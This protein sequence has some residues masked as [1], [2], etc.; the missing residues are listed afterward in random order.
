[1]N[2]LFI[3]FHLKGHN[4]LKSHAVV[5]H[6]YKKSFYNRYPGQLGISNL[7]YAYYST[8]N[9]TSEVDFAQRFFVSSDS[10]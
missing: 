2:Y 10:I 1:M 7:A 4:I 3:E 6:M 8:T 9:D 5:Y